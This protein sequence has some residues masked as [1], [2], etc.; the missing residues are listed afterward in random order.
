MLESGP[1]LEPTL[2]ALLWLEGDRVGELVGLVLGLRLGDSEGADKQ[3]TE[4]KTPLAPHVITPPPRNPWL[5]VTVK[6]E[7][8]TPA[9]EPANALSE[10]GTCVDKQVVGRSAAQVSVLNTPEEPQVVVPPPL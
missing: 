2:A 1:S 7:P 5:Q 4:L 3:A 6:V 10:C 8:T 9:M